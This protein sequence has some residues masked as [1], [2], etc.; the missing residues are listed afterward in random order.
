[1]KGVFLAALVLCQLAFPACS[2]EPE[3]SPSI[4]EVKAQHESHLLEEPGVV[5]VGIGRDPD[6]NPAIVVGIDGPRPKTVERLPR[7][8]G[9]YPVITRI[10]GRV[11]AQ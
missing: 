7:A 2:Q 11:K 5:S 9:G 1:V 4:A 10:L 3:I 6:G 8:L